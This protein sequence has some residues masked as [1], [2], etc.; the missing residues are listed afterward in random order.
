MALSYPLDQ[1]TG[2]GIAQIEL[3]AVHAVVAS[4]SPFTFKQQVV[5]HQGQRWEA[6]VT[7]PSVR[8]SCSLEEHACRFKGT[9]RYIPYGRS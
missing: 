2:I 1:P 5:A 3:R 4:Q 8:S 9:N 7:I 6:S